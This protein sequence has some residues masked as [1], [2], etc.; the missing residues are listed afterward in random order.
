MSKKHH[1]KGLIQFDITNI[2]ENIVKD[3]FEDIEKRLQV[4]ETKFDQLSHQ[5]QRS[6]E[7]DQK[8]STLRSTQAMQSCQLKQQNE[9][10]FKDQSKEINARIKQLNKELNIQYEEY[11][12]IETDYSLSLS[13]IQI[14]FTKQEINQIQT[15]FQTELHEILSKQQIDEKTKEIIAK[16]LYIALVE[17]ALSRKNSDTFPL[18]ER[19]REI[20]KEMS[21]SLSALKKQLKSNGK[22]TDQKL[23]TMKSEIIESIDVKYSKQLS[24]I[25]T[26]IPVF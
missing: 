19:I 8:Q 3:R 13:R 9:K 1:S 17:E 5:P 4:L 26:G 15:K 12:I 20:E 22:L 6:V 7:E 25:N 2:I 21:D 18:Y 14:Q 23:E 16:Q 11:Q 10:K 24:A